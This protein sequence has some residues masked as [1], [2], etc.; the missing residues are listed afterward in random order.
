M[1]DGIGDDIIAIP[2]LMQVKKQ[3]QKGDLWLINFRFKY[4]FCIIALLNN[5]FMKA[6]LI[7]A[8]FKTKKL[9][10]DTIS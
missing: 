10:A 7:Y 4:I 6:Y 3:T 2:F 1:N 9:C 5:E 8:F